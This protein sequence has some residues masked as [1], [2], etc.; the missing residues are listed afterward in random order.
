MINTA[1]LKQWAAALCREVP[2]AAEAAATLGLGGNVVPRG[3]YADLMPPPAGASKLMI[4]NGHDGIGHVDVTLGDA[5]IT[6]A[7]LDAAFGSGSVLPRIGPGRPHKVAYHVAV[8]G[9]PFTC[10][11]F[12]E[13]EEPPELSV[14]ATTIILRR[15]RA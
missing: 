7:D 3:D 13:F 5:H 1:R 4:V 8:Q 14:A 15:D 12:G 10:E 9:A 11:V 6:R 2:G